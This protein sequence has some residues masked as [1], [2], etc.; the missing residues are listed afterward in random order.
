MESYQELV[1]SSKVI[2][3][4]GHYGFWKSR[5]KVV[6]GSI[7]VLTWKSVLVQWEAPVNV[8]A[9]GVRTPKPEETW[10]EDELKKAKFNSRA[11]AAIHCSV[12]RKNFKLI[13]GCETAKETW[14][15]LQTHY[16][17][18]QKVQ[19]SRRDLI[20]SRFENLKMEEH[21]SIADFSSKLKS[22][23]QEAS[24]LGKKNK[25]Q[26]LVKKFLRCLPSKFMAYKSALNVSQN[27]EDF[28]FGEVV[29]MLQAHEIDLD[30]V[31]LEFKRTKN[32]ALTSC[33]K[34]EHGYNGENPM[35]LLV[36]RFDRALR[37]VEQEQGQ[38]GFKSVLK[39][40]EVDRASR[41]SEIQ[42]Y[43][44]KW[45]NHVKTECLI[46]KR[47]DIRCSSCKGIRHTQLECV[48]DQK[49]RGER[50]MLPETD[51]EEDSAD[52]EELNNFVASTGIIEEESDSSDSESDEEHDD[53][54][55]R[56]KPKRKCIWVKK[57]D[58]KQT[59][60]RS[61][62]TSTSGLR[63]C[64]NMAILSEEQEDSGPWYFDSG[65]SRHMTGTMSNLQTLD[66][67]NE[68]KVTF[69]DGSHGAV[70]GLTVSFTSIDC[71]AV[72]K[73]G[74]TTLRGVRSGDN[75]YSHVTRVNQNMLQGVSQFKGGDQLEVNKVREE[76][77]SN[78]QPESDGYSATGGQPILDQTK[79]SRVPRD[80]SA[81]YDIGGVNEGMKI[82]GIKKGCQDPEHLAFVRLVCV[83]E[84][85]NHV[86]TLEDEPWIRT[87]GWE[88]ILRSEE[89]KVMEARIPSQAEAVA[90]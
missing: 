22:L 87:N 69:G 45:Y 21:E 51:S 17:G 74:T 12:S 61:A 19:N 31:A 27:T 42:C 33:E 3:D 26:K 32:L 2:L 58:L 72:D 90:S 41:K 73:D 47:R 37:K 85:E 35:S 53:D 52:E 55:A 38:R 23:A 83:L 57:T 36:R 56:K 86:E 77:A 28:S 1:N 75:C 64:C 8:D 67:T 46:V 24:T 49:S 84:P 89:V 82:R 71:K 20:A 40:P 78:E 10:T 14:N 65:C 30:S 29:G 48:N 50:Y 88:L 4:A 16:E 25:D 66:T 39:K 79:G 11:L 60:T 63:F 70:Q 80:H 5:M 15:L 54:L 6:I 13:Q 43:E 18:T 81:T 62:S 7:D 68:G 9:A 44:C 59:A 34:K 76:S